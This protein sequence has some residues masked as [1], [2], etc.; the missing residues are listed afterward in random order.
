MNRYP[1]SVSMIIVDLVTDVT[2]SLRKL[3]I[4]LMVII[5]MDFKNT[6]IQ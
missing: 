2:Q 1:L 6:M 3:L 4:L 5:L